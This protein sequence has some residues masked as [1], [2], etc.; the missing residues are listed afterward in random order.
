M[1]QI[2]LRLMALVLFSC[3]WSAVYAEKITYNFNFSVGGTGTLVYDDVS[4]NANPITMD[5][6]S[7]GSLVTNFNA[8]STASIFGAPPGTEVKADG[9]FFPL[10]RAGDISNYASVRLYINGSFCVR[11][12]PEIDNPTCVVT[13]TYR[14]APDL[15]PEAYSGTYSFNFSGAG[16]GYFKYD[17]SSGRIET[18]RYDFGDF[19]SG[20]TSFNE[21]LTA[22]V[23][24]TPPSNAVIQ[25]NTF[26]T[27]SGGS[28]YG[29]R[30]RT[31]GSFCVRPDAGICGDG[32]ADLYS[33]TYLITLV[34]E[35]SLPTGGNVVAVPEIVD[36]DGVAIQEPTD[37]VLTFDSVITEGDL[38]V[39]V[40][41][42][43]S[44]DAPELP[45]G[46]ALAGT[47][48]FYDITTTA[49]FEESVEVCLGYSDSGVDESLIRLYHL[50]EGQWKDITNEGSPDTT[51]NVICGR[52]NSFSVFV[53]V[54]PPGDSDG[55]GL[56]DVLEGQ[57]GT[58]P[59]DADTDGDGLDDGTEVNITHT[60]PLNRD[61]DGD[62]LS[63]GE[64]VAGG[65]NP[66]LWDTDGDGVGDAVDPLPLVPGV[67]TG[68]IEEE[69]RRLSADVLTYDLALMDARND[70][71]RKG[72]RNA[73]SNQINGAANDVAAGSFDEAASG[74]TS[75]LGKIDD[76]SDPPDWMIGGEVKT[77]LRN[78]IILMR[79]L[80]ELQPR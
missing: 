73:I 31:D 41:S 66:L 55:D 37:I 64:E 74:L 80:I 75:L 50:H 4:M 71:A 60:D 48:V 79:G 2:I 57:L 28:A 65:T 67:T 12:L 76:Q 62:G 21:S 47:S 8:T 26:F 51:N 33:G 7:F 53:P 40:I 59:F 3:T 49:V 34:A 15:P 42:T 54:L 39:T 69:L 6:G 5:F 35:G 32:T 63:D 13:G 61:S 68:F 11:L 9:V 46:F 70:N 72:R 17:G 19:G 18:L 43:E 10:K 14:I 1:P 36:E 16:T 44:P 29:L 58:N 23:F 56:S 78:N 24:G 38:T 45:S 77:S 20:A 52:T 30:L 22:L 25:D 27:L